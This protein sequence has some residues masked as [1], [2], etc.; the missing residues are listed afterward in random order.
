[1]MWAPEALQRSRPTSDGHF[2]HYDGSQKHRLEATSL[3]VCVTDGPPSAAPG[4]NDTRLRQIAD[5]TM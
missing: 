2:A 1:M 4:R 3:V 5:D